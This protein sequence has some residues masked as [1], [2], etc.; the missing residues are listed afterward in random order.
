[1][2]T[3]ETL[4]IL[5]LLMIAASFLGATLNDLNQHWANHPPRFWTRFRRWLGTFGRDKGPW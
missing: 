4:I 2:L 1:M 3:N 5:T